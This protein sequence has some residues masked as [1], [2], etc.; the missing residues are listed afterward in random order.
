MSC[1]AAVSI[2]NDLLCYEKLESGKM[3]LHKE[4]VTIEP[5]LKNCLSLFAAQ[6]NECGVT[7]TLDVEAPAESSLPSY[8]S[9][10]IITEGVPRMNVKTLGIQ[11]HDAINIDRFK[12]DQVVRNLLS[13]ALKFTPRGGSVTVKAS[14]VH[15][16]EIDMCDPFSRG[17]CSAFESIESNPEVLAR[18]VSHS[19]ATKFC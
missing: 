17:S 10:D 19:K 14:F 11:P 12:M 5:F 13:N 8:T 9:Q 7:I 1:T 16:T 4:A 2:L 6:A 15:S 18:P 3:E